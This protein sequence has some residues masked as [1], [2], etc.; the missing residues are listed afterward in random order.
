MTR[1][2]EYLNGCGT[3]THIVVVGCSL[4]FQV[5]CV[6][7]TANICDHI[8]FFSHIVIL[9]IILDGWSVHEQ[10]IETTIDSI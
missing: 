8:P 7:V 5:K 9:I 3:H 10:R 1:I 2:L 4:C 6:C